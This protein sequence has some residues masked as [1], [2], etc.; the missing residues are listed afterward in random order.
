MTVVRTFSLNYLSS[1][2]YK[3]KDD[4]QHQI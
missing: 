1:S 4:T 3:E 2:T